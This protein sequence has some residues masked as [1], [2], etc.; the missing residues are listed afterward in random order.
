MENFIVGVYDTMLKFKNE[1]NKQYN[2][3][4]NNYETINR[5]IREIISSDKRILNKY[6]SNELDRLK[7][8]LKGDLK[9][10]VLDLKFND[11]NFEKLNKLKDLFESLK[12]IDITEINNQNQK[13]QEK[14][15]E[16]LQL[17]E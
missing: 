15:Q 9:G 4:C 1:I 17:I 8:D 14:T 3:K 6:Y 12:G 11:Q 2:D 16:I 5:N 7:G 10:G 13:L